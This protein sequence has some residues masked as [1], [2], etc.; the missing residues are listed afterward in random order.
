MTWD[1]ILELL[2]QGEGQSV[3]FEKGIPTEDDIARELVAFSNADGGKIIYG[4]DD[5]N[6]HLIGVNID[7][8]FEDWIKEISKSHC[9]PAIT[10][11]IEIFDKGDKKIVILTIPEGIDRPYKTD[12]LCY[13]RDGNVSRP[14]KEN[15]EKEITNPWSGKGLNKRQIRALAIIGEHSAITNREYREAFNVSHK[16]AHLELTILEDK[17][18]VKSEGAGRSTRYILSRSLQ[19]Q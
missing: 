14:A 17:K 6:K 5:K 8:H 19:E 7:N 11:N 16:T 9:T 10:P 15:E 1:E 12:D 4:I 2:E 3:E 13:I 18:M